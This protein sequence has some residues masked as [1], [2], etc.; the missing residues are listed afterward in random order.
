MNLLKHVFQK[1]KKD[2]KLTDSLKKDLFEKLFK[3][4]KNYIQI[5]NN[6]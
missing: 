4:A 3:F 2:T 5:N 6:K 1:N